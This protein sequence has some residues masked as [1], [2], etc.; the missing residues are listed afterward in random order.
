MTTKS[1]EVYS[2]LQGVFGVTVIV[3][4]LFVP[5]LIKKMNVK[6]Y[7]VGASI[8]GVGILYYGIFYSI[9]QFFIGAILVGIGLPISSLVRVYLIQSLVPENKLGRAFSSN[10]VLLYLSNTVSL[11]IFGLLATSIPIQTLM[12]GSG[13]VILLISLVGLLIFNIK[14]SKSSRRFSINPFK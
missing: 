10:A 8:W 1:E 14:A 2:M 7:L 4:N 5:F 6:I 9:E 11:A 3:T 12:I 13:L